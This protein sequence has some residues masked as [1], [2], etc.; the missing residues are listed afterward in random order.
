MLNWW[1]ER[2]LE[3]CYAVPADGRYADQKY[4]DEVPRLFPSVAISDLPGLNCAPWN[5]VGQKVARRG[6]FV[7][8]S[9]LPLLLYHFQGLR[10]MRRWALDYYASRVV[11]SKTV[12]EEIYRP[13]AEALIFHSKVAA[14]QA[15]E[16]LLGID[17]DFIGWRGL[18][19]AARELMWSPN[20]ATNFVGVRPLN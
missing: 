8:V 14:I 12:K 13:Y 4:L 17:S 3:S 20:I 10:V 7:L 15:G 11:L 1:Q 18:Y 16:P 2:C 6:G 19:R 9:G 5:V